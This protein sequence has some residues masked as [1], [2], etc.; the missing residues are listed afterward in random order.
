MILALLSGINFQYINTQYIG[1]LEFLGG[2]L[3]VVL[4]FLAIFPRRKKNQN[5]DELLNVQE[6]LISAQEEIKEL[7]QRIEELEQLNRSKNDFLTI[8]AHDLKSPVNSILGLNEVVKLSEDADKEE[9]EILIGKMV[10]AGRNVKMLIDNLMSWCINN[11]GSVTPIIEK[12]SV[13][14]VAEKSRQVYEFLAED[15]QIDLQ[16]DIDSDI[17]LKADRDHVFTILRNI[18]N[19]ALK[20]T[21]NGGKVV[22]SA[23]KKGDYC[24][25]KIE[26][27]GVGMA[28]EK[29]NDILG[30][31]ADNNKPV[32][33]LTGTRG[34]AGNG[35]GLTICHDLITLNNGKMEI[36]S[37]LG[38]GTIFSVSLP[39]FKNM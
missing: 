29:V 33:S 2:L 38:H 18:I 1:G 3:L 30:S 9:M 32:H 22:I 7:N 8:L 34:E 12:V 16:I 21:H 37:V 25:L 5:S 28:V 14:E 39:V 6:K 26:D 27:T 4:L 20:F 17:H 11:Q 19:N 31:L 15:K 36:E 10:N 23:F 35:L 24:V 13:L